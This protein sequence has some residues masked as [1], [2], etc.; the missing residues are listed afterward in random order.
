[1]P[2]LFTNTKAIKIDPTG[3]VAASVNLPA[4]RAGILIGGASSEYVWVA[5]LDRASGR[6]KL[7]RITVS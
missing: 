2:W 4:R 7:V 1:V 3:N 5:T 6:A